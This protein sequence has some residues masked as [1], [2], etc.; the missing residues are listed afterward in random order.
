M[1]VK[2]PKELA[3]SEPIPRENRPMDA[4][5]ACSRFS[6]PNPVAPPCSAKAIPVVVPTLSDVGLK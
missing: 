6:A 4:C 1:R 3:I 2:A 5:S